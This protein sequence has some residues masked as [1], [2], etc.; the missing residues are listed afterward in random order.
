MS[1]TYTTKKERIVSQKNVKEY[2]EIKGEDVLYAGQTAS[3]LIGGEYY[4]YTINSTTGNI[5]INRDS[6]FRFRD[7]EEVGTLNIKTKKI[8]FTEN[9]NDY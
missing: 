7:R 6:P 3:N 4:D 2:V 9:A 1:E 5:T 8:E